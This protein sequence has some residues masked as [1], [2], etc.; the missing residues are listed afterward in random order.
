MLEKI[1]IFETSNQNIKFITRIFKI[2]LGVKTKEQYKLK[3]LAIYFKPCG[4][5]IVG[6]EIST[7]Y[8]LIKL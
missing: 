4:I 3:P 8:S 1:S 2:R 5:K 7:P 6:R